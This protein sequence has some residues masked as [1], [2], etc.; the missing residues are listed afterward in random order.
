MAAFWCLTWQEMT[1]RICYSTRGRHIG[2]ATCCSWLLGPSAT[3]SMPWGNRALGW[4]LRFMPVGQRLCWVQRH[5]GC[6]RCL[7]TLQCA[8]SDRCSALATLWWLILAFVATWPML[9]KTTVASGRW[10]GGG[11]MSR[12]PV[13]HCGAHAEAR[14]LSWRWWGGPGPEKQA[15]RPFMLRRPHLLKA[16]K[17]IICHACRAFHAISGKRAWAWARRRL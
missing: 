1:S 13:W 8:R 11:C 6:M 5:E 12:C 15:M 7:R 9:C 14:G 4:T 2:A 3:Y 17:A 10:R 16:S